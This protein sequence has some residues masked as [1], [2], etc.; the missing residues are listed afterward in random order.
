[1]ELISLTNHYQ[2]I[3]VLNK[4]HFIS[5]CLLYLLISFSGFCY[6]K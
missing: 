2:T 5:G 6:L 4:N 3:D 1:M